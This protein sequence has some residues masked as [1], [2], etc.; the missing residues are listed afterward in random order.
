MLRRTATALASLVALVLLLVGT[1]ST[2]SAANVDDGTY[3]VGQR[4]C[5]KA[6]GAGSVSFTV[7][8]Y[9]TWTNGRLT[10]NFVRYTVSP[11]VG[12]YPSSTIIDYVNTDSAS[13]T[14]SSAYAHWTYKV[15]S[16][17]QQRWSVSSTTSCS[18]SGY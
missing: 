2:A 10:S 17:S 11:S 12:Y 3:L 6:L 8:H 16:A 7:K 14:L 9:N 13:A 15:W 1:S 4:S 18:L 5:S